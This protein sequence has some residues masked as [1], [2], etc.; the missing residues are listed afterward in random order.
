MRRVVYVFLTFIIS[1]YFLKIAFKKINFHLLYKYTH[2]ISI[3][4]ALLAISFLLVGYLIRIHRWQL[5]L[6]TQNPKIGWTTICFPYFISFSLNNLI[7]LRAGDIYRIYSLKRYGKTLQLV[8]STLITERLLDII[9][10]FLFF[11]FFVFKFNLLHEAL[12]SKILMFFSLA[13]SMAIILIILG[14]KL[15]DKKIKIVA[16]QKIKKLLESIFLE[17]SKILRPNKTGLLMTLSFFAWSFECLSYYFA[18][19]SIK[20]LA[21]PTS[22]FFAFPVGTLST[23]IPSSPGYLGT[24]DFFVIKSMELLGNTYESSSL[25]SILIHTILWFPI[26]IIGLIFLLL[27][28]NSKK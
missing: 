11:C 1:L 28:Q 17:V 16:I 10:I 25:Y 27:S 20:F 22:A 3:S 5:M 2:N 7:P 12:T 19:L 8:T 15:K 4:F 14:I 21:F 6:N 9:I 13:I 23:L 24:F 18:A 26:T